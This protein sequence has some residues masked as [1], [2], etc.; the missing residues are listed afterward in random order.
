M[1]NTSRGTRAVRWIER[2]CVVPGGPERGQHVRL[3]PVQRETVRRIYDGP[4]G[5]EAVPTTGPLAAYLALMHV[6]GPEALQQDFRPAV[7]ADIFTVW[8][9]TGPDLREV[10]RLEHGQITCPEIGTRYPNP[11]AA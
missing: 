7:A 10:L 5:S 3:S 9:A 8:N 6:C 11:A 4:Q 1:A 2:F